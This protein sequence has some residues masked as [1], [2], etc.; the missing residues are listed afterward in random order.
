M[1]AWWLDGLLALGLL[2]LAWQAV[3]APRLFRSVVMF[4]VFGLFMSLCWARLAAPDLALAEAAIGAGLTGA[5][6]LSAYRA[7]LVRHGAGRE[8]APGIA[9]A[10]ARVIAVGSGVLFAV[11]AGILLT[12][13]GTEVPAGRAA[14]A[15]ME[16]LAVDNPV[17]GVLLVFRAYDTLMEMGVLLLALLGARVVAEPLRAAGP[18]PWRRPGLSEPVLVAPLV[19]LLVPLIVLV[20]GYLLWAGTTAPGGAFQAGAV[21][22]ALGVLLRLTG[23]LRPTLTNSLYERAVLVLGLAVFT[24]AG[25]LGLGTEGYMLSYPAG[26]SYPLILVVETTL[27]LSI[28]LT[29]ALLFSGSNGFRGAR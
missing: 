24:A 19:A 15:R 11:L 25:A 26:W 28:A 14:L 17:T 16:E 3:T 4:I 12:L 10:L 5:L 22:A 6:L 13:P 21:L 20:A 8:E 23:R 1:M 29:L 2:W 9:P 7:L 27:M 18:G